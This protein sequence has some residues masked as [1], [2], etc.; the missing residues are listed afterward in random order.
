MINPLSTCLL[1]IGCASDA[2]QR[3]LTE[4]VEEYVLEIMWTYSDKESDLRVGASLS[5]RKTP[6]LE[7][8]ESSKNIDYTVGTNL[9]LGIRMLSV[10]ALYTAF[11][12]HL[13]SNAFLWQ[14][15]K[16]LK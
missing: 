3:K 6:C 16:L 7:F 15:T 8:W 9:F 14:V 1:V 10:R 12:A 5:M 13:E 11:D 4:Y 2:C